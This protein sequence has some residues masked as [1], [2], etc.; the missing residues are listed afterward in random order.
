MISVIITT[1]DGRKK[2]CK[3][4]IESVIAQ[5]HDNWELI[6]VDDA[7]K[8]GTDKMVAGFKDSRIKYLKRETNFGNHSRPKNEGIKTSTGEYVAFLD[9]DN[10]YRPDHLTALMKGMERSG[11][12]IV[13]GD[14]WIVYPDGKGELGFTSDHNP[15]TLLRRPYIDT[16]D[17]LMKREAMD[18]LGGWDEEHQ[19]LLDWQLMVR[20]AKAGFRFQRIP[21]IITDYHIHD[22]MLSNQMEEGQQ[23]PFKPVWDVFDCK[24]R[25][26]YLNGEPSM[27]RVAVFTITYDRINY[28][29]KCLESLRKKAGYRYD[30]FIVDN[31]SE[32]STPDWIEKNFHNYI[33]NEDN[34]G[35]AIASNQA[36]DLIGDKYDII[37]KVDNDC[38]FLTDKWL[39]KMVEIWQ[40]NH[41]IAMSCYVQG[42]RDNPGGAPRLHYGQIQGELIGMTKHVGGICH[43]VSAKA[44]KNFRWDETQPLHGV[45]DLE[46]SQYL[47][48]QGYSMGYLENFICEH[49]DGTEGQLKRYPGYFERRKSEKVE[50]YKRSYKEIQE[51]ESA[52]SR[53]T[54]WGDRLKDSVERY[55]QYLTG[56]VLD[57]GCGDGY[58]LEVMEGLGIDAWGSDI[59]LPKIR[60]AWDK[61]LK[62]SCGPMENMSGFYKDGEFDTIFC[63]HTL[64]HSQDIKQAI[65]EMKRLAKRAVIIVPIESAT[66]NPAH[67][68]PISSPEKLKKLLSG[69][70]LFE[71]ELNRMEPEYT[72]VVEW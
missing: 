12:D 25:L 53:G 4:A 21:G 9:S 50:S 26:P 40:S 34:K 24:I 63:S 35:I 67:T 27:P 3:R 10:V 5:T 45:Q 56:K 18:Y 20:A 59:S 51:R 42:L 11:A 58:G 69:K 6:V 36:L 37:V 17:F 29:K 33:L 2:M 43:F 7:S 47:L 72:V 66:S 70:V 32:D 68:S 44:Y 1:H 60:K 54:P 23:D 41:M 71:E 62:A 28:T 14:R 8:D 48:K 22:D 64:E 52:N 16:S 38:L 39:A 13:Y 65:S 15:F 61:G 46:L 19:R 49:I 55:K 30:H 57:I 31:G